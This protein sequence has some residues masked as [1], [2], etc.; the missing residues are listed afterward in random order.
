M[1]GHPAPS[2][3]PSSFCFCL[4]FNN[5]P[6]NLHQPDSQPEGTIWNLYQELVLSHYIPEYALPSLLLEF[7][8]WEAVSPAKC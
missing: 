7:Q 6:L 3:P 2:P 4:L 8:E 5:D 1:L